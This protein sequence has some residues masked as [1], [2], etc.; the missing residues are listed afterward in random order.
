MEG[1]SSRHL[2]RKVGT[3]TEEMGEASVALKRGWMDKAH[4][5]V[6]PVVSSLGGNTGVLVI[7]N[8]HW[9]PCFTLLLLWTIL[10]RSPLKSDYT[11]CVRGPLGNGK[12]RSDFGLKMGDKDGG[13]GRCQVP[14][15]ARQEEKFQEMS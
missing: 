1:F 5:E 9:R 7:T 15:E 4:E 2:E 12:V 8:V 13:R 10:P 14:Q 3:R 11:C 6:R